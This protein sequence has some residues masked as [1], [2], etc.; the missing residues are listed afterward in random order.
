MPDMRQIILYGSL[1][2][3]IAATVWVSVNE[4]DEQIVEPVTKPQ[5][6]ASG[7]VTTKAAPDNAVTA[8]NH[9]PS[10]GKNLFATPNSGNI[11]S[12]THIPAVPPP[13]VAMASNSGV[14][15]FEF[16]GRQQ[17]KAGNYIFISFQDRTLSLK[18]G[19]TVD[20][21]YRLKHI[22]KNTVEWVHIPSKEM[23][24]MNIEGEQP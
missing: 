22:R 13:P 23:I 18:E 16:L 19:D 12:G 15:P 3:T 8:S 20:S 9:V 14:L 4:S 17:S 24:V 10:A 2:A 7:P 21:L 5:A 1:L 11:P 6:I